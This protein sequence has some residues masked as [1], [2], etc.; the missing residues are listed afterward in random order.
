MEVWKN[1]SEKYAV[2]NA[3]LVKNR[4]TG[5]LLTHEVQTRK[6]KYGGE[7][8]QH[9]VSM[10]ENGIRKH[11]L[12]HRLVA[13]TFIPNPKNKPQVNHIDGNPENNNV[14]NLE[15]AT[16]SENQIHRCKVLCH[17]PTGWVSCQRPVMCI[18]TGAR[19]KSI[20]EAARLEGGNM[21]GLWKALA[22]NRKSYHKKHWAYIEG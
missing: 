16:A 5:K 13:Q 12:V 18:E 21:N 17:N 1:I 8:K 2:S 3:G 11:Y 22:G 20:S 15:W 9:R 7:Y 14:E 4:E 6:R 10:L 19:Y